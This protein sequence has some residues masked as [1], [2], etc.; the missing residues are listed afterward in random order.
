M[1]YV[2]AE[3]SDSSVSSVPKKWET[4]IGKTKKMYFPKKGAL[5]KIKANVDA[6]K[7]S[8]KWNLHSYRLLMNGGEDDKCLLTY[9]GV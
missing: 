1:V 4:M 5:A 6:V 2:V 9:L 7:G 3:F 8:K